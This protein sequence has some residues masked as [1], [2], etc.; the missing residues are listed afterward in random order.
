MKPIPSCILPLKGRNAFTL[1]LQGGDRE[2]DGS[3]PVCL[4]VPG[5]LDVSYGAYFRMYPST[6]ILRAVF[7][8]L[9]Y[10]IL[11]KIGR[12]GPQGRS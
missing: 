6:R 4:N 1:P 11:P 10:R 5:P 8:E 2:G 12:S 3:E 7:W 9:M